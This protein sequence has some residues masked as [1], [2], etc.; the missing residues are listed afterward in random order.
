MRCVASRLTVGSMLLAAALAAPLGAQD[1]STAKAAPKYRA[2]VL[3]VFDGA[4][5]EPLEGVRVLDV[6]NGNSAVTT[7]TG[8]VSLAFL[9]DGGSLVRVQHIGYATQT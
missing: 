8:T 7:R 1:T 6:L 4:S 2:R 5:G 9:P 3:G